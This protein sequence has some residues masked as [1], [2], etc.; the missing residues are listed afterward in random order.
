M[1][2]VAM[3]LTVIALMIT[4]SAVTGTF[5]SVLRQHFSGCRRTGRSGKGKHIPAVSAEPQRIPD[6][7]WLISLN[8]C[9]SSSNEYECFAFDLNRDGNSCRI[10]GW[11]VDPEIGGRTDAEAVLLDDGQLKRI[12]GCLKSGGFRVCGEREPEE[13]VYDGVSGMLCADR[14]LPDGSTV[15][16]RYSGRGE[17]ELLGLLKLFLRQ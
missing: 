12:E 16:V 13:G 2:H 17:K 11:F 7:A 15:P 1:S 3:A 14:R 6:G 10:S 4:V 9:R 8:W 5:F